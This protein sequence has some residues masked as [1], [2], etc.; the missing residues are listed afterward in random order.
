MGADPAVHGLVNAARWP[1]PRAKEGTNLASASAA[2]YVAAALCLLA[3]SAPVSAEPAQRVAVVVGRRAP[4]IERF[5]ADELCCYLRELFGLDS[6]P[7]HRAPASA[8]AILLVGGP[9]SNPA[10][11]QALADAPWPETSDQAIVL[12]RL[13]DARP[14]MLVA[15]SSPRATLWAVYALAEHWGVRFLLHG[16]VLPSRRRFRLPDL[17]LVQE[18][19]LPI[20]QWRVVNDFACGPE[21]WG[22][23]D[24]RPILDQLAKLRFNRV[25]L[26]TWT[27]QPFL[28]LQVEG[29]RRTHATLWYDYH[30]PITDD[31]IGRALFADREEFWNPDLP[32]GAP[33]EELAAA[34]ERHLHAIMAHARARGMQAA[35]SVALTEFPPEF[36]PLLPGC[37]QVQQLGAMGIVPGPDTPLDDP[38]LTKLAA[39][40]LQTTVNT[41]PEVDYLVLGMPE[42]RQWS[43]AYE[44]AWRALDE[45]YGIARTRA[46]SDV[47]QAA[48]NRPD[49]PG[50]ADRAVQEVKGDIVALYFYDRLIRDLRVLDGTRR[51]D[52]RFVFNSVAEELF[53]ILA[54]IAPP[55]AETMNFVDYTPAR[56]VKRRD[57]LRRVPAREIP[58]T[59][60]YTLHD[61][62]VGLLP[63]LATGSLHEL[64]KDL[65]DQGWAGFSTRYWLIA[66]HDPCVAYL[67]RAAWD[68]S[69]TPEAV[70]R[71]QI[72]AACGEAAVAD[73][74]TVFREVEATTMQLEWHGLGLTFPVPG[75]MMQHWAAGPMSAELVADREGY[76][77]ALQAAERAHAKATAAGKG[78]TEYWIGRLR[79]GI[80]Y[81]D[82][83]EALHRAATAEAGGKQEET[84][85][86]ARAALT[87]ATTAL[88]AYA[89]VARDRSDLGALAVMN[90]YVYRPLRAKVAELEKGGAAP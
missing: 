36:A 73:M 25:F 12:R 67:A 32:R 13:P 42:F 41:Y 38:A 84:L 77:R 68:A 66:D 46:L 15:G 6:R 80:G 35:M 69:A 72:A 61:D 65:R 14:T 40:V 1:E 50:G 19:L 89:G 18:P 71:D 83:I 82:A 87:A 78:Y 44:Q 63:Q 60:I 49:Y 47:L 75:M 4:E 21:S 20:R 59:L 5:A 76:R 45:R 53:P 64:T 79:F 37:Q 24:Y 52:V 55:G 3:V 70:Y 90:E 57:A 11:Q 9:A 43:G 28:D 2:V 62:N 26:S 81:L 27:Y 16:D 10:V 31:M 23:A 74:L 54:Q 88:E 30:Y 58:S 85:Q 22:I 8:D 86:E 48:A 7:T 33:Y 34:G 29:I 39:A 17:D 51:P 56:I